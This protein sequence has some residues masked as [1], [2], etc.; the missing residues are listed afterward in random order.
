MHPLESAAFARRTPKA[1]I[2]HV[3][4]SDICRANCADGVLS[5]VATSAP[6]RF[7]FLEQVFTWFPRRVAPDHAEGGNGP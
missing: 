3:L 1:V 7:R 2:R 6:R 5:P 4:K